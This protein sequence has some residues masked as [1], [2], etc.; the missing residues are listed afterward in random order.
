[1]SLVGP[2][3][4]IPYEVEEYEAWHLR[5]LQTKPGLTG[6]WQVKARGSAEFDEMVKLDIR[7]IEHQSFWLDLKIILETPRAVLGGQGAV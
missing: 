4:P 7:Y 1:M 3:P 6:L 5:R 2:R